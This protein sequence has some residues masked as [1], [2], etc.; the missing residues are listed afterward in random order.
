MYFPDDDILKRHKLNKTGW[1]LL[2][3]RS[4]TLYAQVSIML[5]RGMKRDKVIKTIQEESSVHDTVNIILAI[6]T[7]ELRNK[8][9][10]Y[11]NLL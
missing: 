6:T 4:S 8:T 1:Y 11:E 10:K 9:F 7:Y 3:L 5:D 2:Q